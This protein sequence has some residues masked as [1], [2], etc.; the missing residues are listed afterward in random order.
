MT[1]NKKNKIEKLLQISSLSNGWKSVHKII[2][3]EIESLGWKATNFKFWKV[4]SLIKYRKNVK[5]FIYIGLRRFG[6]KVAD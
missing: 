3:K 2:S 6:G 4:K 5:F 1:F